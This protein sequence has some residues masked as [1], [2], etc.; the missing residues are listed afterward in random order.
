MFPTLSVIAIIPSVCL[1]IFRA[2]IDNVGSIVTITLLCIKSL[3]RGG[4]EEEE[5]NCSGCKAY[6]SSDIC[7]GHTEGGYNKLINCYG[8]V[9]H[10]QQER[11]KKR[12]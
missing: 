3:G 9:K 7:S 11:K 5:K 8:S 1:I 6:V 2:S 12:L 4:G 10:Q